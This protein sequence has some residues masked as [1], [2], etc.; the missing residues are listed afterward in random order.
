MCLKTRLL[1]ASFFNASTDSGKESICLQG[2]I[3]LCKDLSENLIS[4]LQ[5]ISGWPE[6]QN[7]TSASV[8]KL[9]DFVQ[10]VTPDSDEVSESESEDSDNSDDNDEFESVYVQ[11]D[12]DVVRIGTS[13]NR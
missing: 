13:S 3:P 12:E 10:L 8:K 6:K 5:F 1:L 11:Y 4:D 7:K 9:P 2:I